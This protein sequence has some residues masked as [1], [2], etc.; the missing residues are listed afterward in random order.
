MFP[1]SCCLGGVTEVSV[2]VPTDRVIVTNFILLSNSS[3]VYVE[4]SMSEKNPE[5]LQVLGP[6]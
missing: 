5:Y 1:C 3:H 6:T 4:I 2:Q